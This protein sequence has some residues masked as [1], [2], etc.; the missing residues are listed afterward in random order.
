MIDHS[1][2]LAHI[3]NFEDLPKYKN[4]L[5]SY[6]Y[7]LKSTMYKPLE[8]S[9]NNFFQIMTNM[10]EK[11][12]MLGNNIGIIFLTSIIVLTF[13]Q[14]IFSILCSRNI[15]S[16]ASIFLHISI[17]E[18]IRL[19]K[20][21]ILF[22]EE[23]HSRN[24]HN[25]ASS[26]TEDLYSSG[27]EITKKTISEEYGKI[28]A[29]ESIDREHYLEGKRDLEIGFFSRNDWAWRII[30]TLILTIVMML[31]YFIEGNMH[32]AKIRE[33][34]SL[35]NTTARINQFMITAENFQRYF[36]EEH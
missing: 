14:V 33:I 23:I 30:L 12:I 24:Y 36:F 15:Y 34:N 11:E 20:N 17:R 7:N 16:Q 28:L 25:D 2:L 32:V 21:S 22:F 4:I 29:R 27:E 35:F 3:E 1:F 19:Q 13:I 6:E 8:L 18:C 10:F 5:D 31:L 26:N 9:I